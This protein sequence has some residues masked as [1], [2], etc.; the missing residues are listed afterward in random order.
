MPQP[1][2]D[3]PVD[4]ASLAK[5]QVVSE[6]LNLEEEKNAVKPEVFEQEVAA[7][8][9][10]K[11]DNSVTNRD[12]NPKVTDPRQEKYDD[13]IEAASLAFDHTD[14]HKLSKLDWD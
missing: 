5:Q 14:I 13:P 8:D 9:F 1:V 4:V 2:C 10:Y 6:L 3:A 11:S 7:A 12:Y